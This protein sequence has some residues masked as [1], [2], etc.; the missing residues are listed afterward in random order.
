MII[1]GRMSLF[2]RTF[3]TGK[4]KKL[5]DEEFDSIQR[6]LH[7]TRLLRAG[8]RMAPFRKTASSW[9]RGR[10]FGGTYKA[11]RRLGFAGGGFARTTAYFKKGY[12]RTGGYYGR[13]SG[14]NAELKFHDVDIDD[15]SIT[16]AGTIQNGGSINLIGQSTTESTRIGRKCTI[17][18]I[19]WKWNIQRIALLNASGA[20]GG[21]VVRLIMY[22]DKQANGQTAAVTDILE[23]DNY[24]SFRN[25]ANTSRFRIL[26]DRMITMNPTVGA[27]DGAVN[28]FGSTERMGTFYKSC[29]IP[30]EFSGVA[31]PADITEL[32]SNNLCVLVLSKIGAI[33]VLDSKLRLR[34]SDN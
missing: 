27:G 15:A 32:R 25:L 10:S 29:N 17:K 2:Y 8:V 18:Q 31:N 28:D 5:T 23:S 19:Q 7:P 22:L 12:N 24:E 9:G 33:T 34:F 3:A 14:A 6:G 21:E 20:A 11:K 4:L 1:S 13:F 26:M 16:Q 30:L